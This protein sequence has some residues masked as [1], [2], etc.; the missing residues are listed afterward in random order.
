MG[1]RAR[2]LIIHRPSFVSVEKPGSIL[3]LSN[4]TWKG[5]CGIAKPIYGT[6]ATHFLGL[7]HLSD[8]ATG[9][10]SRFQDWLRDVQTNAVILGGNKQVATSVATGQI[11]WGITDTDDARVEIENGAEIEIIY[12]DQDAN[13]TNPLGLQDSIGTLLIPT[14]ISIIKN[15]P[16]P[17]AA[18]KLAAYL[19][20]SETERRF[21]MG[22]ASEFS[23]RRDSEDF[24]EKKR[25]GIKRMIVNYEEAVK[26]WDTFTKMVE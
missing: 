12:P 21:N 14:T 1:A 15:G 22:F 5:K 17:V 10:T 2:V 6:T 4:P 19:A 23:I 16:H 8:L 13:P 3:D 18:G 11:A 7:L 9:S 25:P 24:Y 20:G 26:Y